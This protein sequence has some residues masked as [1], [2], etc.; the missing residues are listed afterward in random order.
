M[1]LADAQYKCAYCGEVLDVPAEPEPD[2][3]LRRTGSG[4]ATERTLRLYG[5]EI[6]R[7]AIGKSAPYDW[8][9]ESEH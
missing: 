2:V 5:R 1:Q 8:A 9:L 4:C 7:C 3:V 6:H